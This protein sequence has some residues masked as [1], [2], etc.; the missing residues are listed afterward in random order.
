ML[1][2]IK[3]KYIEHACTALNE[4][5]MVVHAHLSNHAW[6]RMRSTWRP[7]HQWGL[8]VTQMRGA[9]DHIRFQVRLRVRQDTT[10]AGMIKSTHGCKGCMEVHGGSKGTFS[11][12]HVKMTDISPPPLPPPPP[13]PIPAGGLEYRREFANSKRQLAWPGSLQDLDH[14]TQDFL[15]LAHL[16]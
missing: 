11:C 2:F 10:C 1:G 7:C 12:R 8:R 5:K 3:L 6:Q 15:M 14:C 9:C 4:A 16:A 13:P